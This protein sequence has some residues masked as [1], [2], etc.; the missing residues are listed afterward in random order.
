ME[1]SK[2]VSHPLRG[3]FS[4]T[5]TLKGLNMQCKKCQSEMT[6]GIAMIPVWGNRANRLERG[7]TLYHISATLRI[8]KKCHSCGY[9]I[10]FHGQLT[11]KFHECPHGGYLEVLDKKALPAR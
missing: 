7:N 1:K 3:A 4:R 9:T 6:E 11:G 5:S 10:S 2:D 8:V